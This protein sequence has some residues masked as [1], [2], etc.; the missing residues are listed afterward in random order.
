VDITL[1]QKP[2]PKKHIMKNHVEFL[3]YIA[4]LAEDIANTT[5]DREEVY[6]LVW[7]YA[8]SSEHVIYYG[9]AHDLVHLVRNWDS[10]LY[11]DA[12]EEVE[13]LFCRSDVMT[14]DKHATVLA[15]CIIRIELTRKVEELINEREASEE[16]A[17]EIA[18]A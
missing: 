15:F 4:A 9:K 14:Y 3:D 16:L 6:D 18:N 8:D 2:K 5:T 10:S 11:N 7:E 13:D 1:K 17:A 12:E